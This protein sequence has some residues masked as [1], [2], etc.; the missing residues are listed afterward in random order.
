MS[1]SLKELSPEEATKIT[2]ELQEVL[3]KYDCEMSVSSAITIM[4]REEEAVLSP[5][6]NVNPGT[7]DNPTSETKEGS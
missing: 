7:N 4:K 3:A 6:Q 2:T 1:Y 5:I